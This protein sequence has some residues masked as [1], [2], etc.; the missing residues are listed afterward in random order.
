MLSSREV[1]HQHPRVF[2]IGYRSACIT[3]IMLYQRVYM[4]KASS[5]HHHSVQGTIKTLSTSESQS[6]HISIP[7]SIQSLCLTI[8]SQY[9]CHHCSVYFCI[10]RPLDCV[11]SRRLKYSLHQRPPFLHPRTV[12]VTFSHH[13]VYHQWSTSHIT[14]HHYLCIHVYITVHTSPL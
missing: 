13:S 3:I 12:Q 4:Y 7:L 5:R 8:Y 1:M 6:S 10:I 11:Y 14:N 9:G 2:I